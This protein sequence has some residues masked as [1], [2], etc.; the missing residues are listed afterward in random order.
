MSEDSPTISFGKKK[1][2][3]ILAHPRGKTNEVVIEESKKDENA[4]IESQMNKTPCLNES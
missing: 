1:L 2:T 4:D 3:R